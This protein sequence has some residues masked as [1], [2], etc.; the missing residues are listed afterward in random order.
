MLAAHQPRLFWI[1][2]FIYVA[3]FFL[4]AVGQSLPGS[5]SIPGYSC[6]FFALVDPI[7]SPLHRYGGIYE[8]KEFE[9][10]SMIV[11]GSIN[12][13]ILGFVGLI[14]C[15]HKSWVANVLRILVPFMIP[16][17]W[18]VFHYQKFY[19]R[20]GYFLWTLG[21]L[22]VLFSNQRKWLT[23]SDGTS[24]VLKSPG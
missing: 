5:R 11:S 21:I 3:S 14:V 13:A 22:L 16:F 15:G 17:C 4:A 8:H 1:G 10:Y 20:E 2:L 23:P 6:A 24:S 12:L 7:Q 18:V 19:P 9:Y